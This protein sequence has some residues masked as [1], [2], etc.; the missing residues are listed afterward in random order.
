MNHPS[1]SMGLL[2]LAPF[3]PTS[4]KLYDV[5]DA[6]HAMLGPALR[7]KPKLLSQAQRWHPMPHLWLQSTWFTTSH[8][9]F[10]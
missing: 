3:N 9:P 5:K 4:T 8:C 1:W 2:I 7:L 6:N 10:N